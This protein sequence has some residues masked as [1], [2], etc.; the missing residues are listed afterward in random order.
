MTVTTK[1]NK[2]I[3]DADRPLDDPAAD[4]LGYV[5]IAT[6]L[7]P[8]LIQTLQEDGVVVGIEGVWGSGKTTLVNY[9]LDEMKQQGGKEIEVIK[10]SPWLSGDG[11]TLVGALLLAMAAAI[12]R[13]VQVTGRWA[14]VKRW[15][16]RKKQAPL[17]KR[18]HQ[19][20]VRTARSAS[21]LLKAGDV[22][23][24]GLGTAG[25]IVDAGVSAFGN[26]ATSKTNEQL[27]A[28]IAKELG[29]TGC[30]FIV[31][32]DDLD[33]LEPAQAVEVVRLVRSVA[34]FPKMLY[35][36]CYDRPVLAHALETGLGVQDGYLFLRKIVQQTFVMPLPEP[37]D[38]R[39]ILIDKAT[40]YF[41]SV[42]GRA[43]TQA[44]SDDIRDAINEWGEVLRTPRDMKLVL[45]GIAFSYA[46]VVEHVHYPDICRLQL[47]KVTQPEVY[48]W[49]ETYLSEYSVVATGDGHV[50]AYGRQLL[51]EE[52]CRLFPDADDFSSPRSRW[53]IQ[54]LAPGIGVST[55]D[56]QEQVF[57]PVAEQTLGN[58][59]GSKRLGSPYHYRYYFALSGARTVLSDAEMDSLLDAAAKG[60]E[61]IHQALAVLYER[62]RR[63][64]GSWFSQWLDRLTSVVLHDL[65]TA[66]LDSL[67]LGIADLMDLSLQREPAGFMFRRTLADRAGSVIRS[68]YREWRGR[69]SQRAGEALLNLLASTKSMNWL[70]GYFFRREMYDHGCVDPSRAQPESEWVMSQQIFDRAVPLVRTRTT[71]H[72]EKCKADSFPDLASFVFG[73][74]ELSGQEVVQSWVQRNT[75]K[76]EDFVDFLLR[77]RSWAV[78]DHVYRPLDSRSLDG[79]IDITAMPERLEAIRER[80][81]DPMTRQHADDVLAAL[82]L[83]DRNR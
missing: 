41:G 64:G 39:L 1:T 49:L 65:T 28:D 5:E 53:R 31:F 72:A 68:L 15:L 75:E 47:I 66:Q 37:F 54:Q 44:E 4:E 48:Q 71:D 42:H 81:S 82:R 78:S 50:G 20:A 14:R 35:I 32:L 36:M 23:V 13:R 57:R 11:E 62:P 61:S 80:H 63:I 9:L 22:L 30:R 3:A 40:S 6:K 7:A 70:V 34:D 74:V 10:L 43:P 52:L 69:D 38:L 83:G 51:D 27:K 17:T 16:R 67:L 2:H 58:L 77:M 19:Y 76:D 59:S 55:V 33:R 25:T 8:A 24:P 60:Y 29:T 12:E 18:L 21:P 46:P 56:G 45:N 26:P 79:L 73:W